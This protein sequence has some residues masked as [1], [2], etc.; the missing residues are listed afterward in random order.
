MGGYV[1][2]ILDYCEV[3]GF[4]A[5]P[6]TVD[7]Y[8]ISADLEQLDQRS[9]EHVHST[10]MKLMFLVQRARRDLLTAVYFLS[11]RWSKATAEAQD[12]SEVCG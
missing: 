10:V 8:E 1:K 11:R 9:Q 12:G 6:A 4:S 2:D 3:T 5:T 7:L